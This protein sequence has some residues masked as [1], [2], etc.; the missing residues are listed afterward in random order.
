VEGQPSKP[1]LKEDEGVP[2]RSEHELAFD[3]MTAAVLLGKS[4]SYLGKSFVEGVIHQLALK[5]LNWK[6]ERVP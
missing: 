2:E 5:C 3:P 4:G 6:T 1:D